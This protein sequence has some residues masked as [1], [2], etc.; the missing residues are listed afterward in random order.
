MAPIFKEMKQWFVLKQD[1]KLNKKTIRLFI[2]LISLSLLL[3]APWK[4]S[5]K[6][7]AVYISEQYSKIYS[8]YPAQIK[9]ILVKNDDQVKKGQSLIEFYSPNLDDQI[10]STKRKLELIKTK[11]NRLSDSAGN[12]DQYITYQQRLISAKS[13]LS[14][15]LKI[16]NKMILKAPIDGSIKDLENLS[17]D[18]WVNNKNELFGIVKHG[19]GQVKGFIKENQ[20]DRFK[21]N[22]TAVFIPNDGMH[23]KINLISKSL[24]YSAI[25]ALP[26]L[27][28]SSTYNGPIA[29]RL[30]AD[31]EYENRPETA[32]YSADFKIM[33]K[34]NIKFELPGYVY[35][36]GYRY[37]PF[38]KFFKNTFSLLIR[39][40]GF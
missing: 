6:I 5:M 35:I 23:K 25:G 34:T 10:N 13:E 2:I 4:S 20:I 32:Y 29:V 24:D 40:S 8:P 38:I 12:M 30:D 14:G 21:L 27:S 26:Y 22:N 36:D 17:N 1:I 28:L 3:F 9:K 7:P 15:L 31:T 33:S 11:I 39:E 18:I 19:T 37:S 16:Q